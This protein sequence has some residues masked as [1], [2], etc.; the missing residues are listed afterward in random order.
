MK[1]IDEYKENQIN[2]LRKSCAQYDVDFELMMKLLK[3]EKIKKTLKT[4]S[5]MQ[6][7][8]NEIIEEN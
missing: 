2:C 3:A 8:I 5:Y 1:R 4:K 7:T 6:Q